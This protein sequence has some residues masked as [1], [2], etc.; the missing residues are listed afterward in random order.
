MGYIYESSTAVAAFY[1]FF[2]NFSKIFGKR[3]KGGSECLFP[4]VSKGSLVQKFKETLTYIY[5]GL[6]VY[7]NL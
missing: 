6:S 3:R 4:I 5:K 1:I 2:V 7:Q